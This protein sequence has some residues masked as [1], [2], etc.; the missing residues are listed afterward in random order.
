[1]S[2][3][4]DFLTRVS[5]PTE[6]RV[7]VIPQV[8]KQA[9]IEI[10]LGE[11]LTGYID[12]R[13][14]VKP[15]TRL[16]LKVAA[17]QLI[18]YFGAHRSL[19]SIT[20]GCADEW[21][22]WLATEVRDGAIVV[23]R[24][25]AENT[26]RRLCGRA[27]QFF[28]A[29]LRKRLISVNPFGNMKRI[30]V[31]TNEARVYFL[32]REDS[33]RVLDACPDG[34]WRVIFALARWG[35]LRCPSE[36]LSLEWSGID[37]DR[38]RMKIHSPKTEH[39]EGGAYRFCPLFPEVRRELSAIYQPGMTGYIVN[40]RRRRAAL[41]I[42]GWQNSNLRTMFR[43]I[44]WRSGVKPWPKVFQNLRSTRE[45]ELCNRFPVHVVCA[46]LGHSALIA[47]KH[48]LQT[49]DQHF[50]AA[51]LEDGGAGNGGAL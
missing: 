13:T 31:G 41:G 40:E 28:L 17:T 47:R 3:L 22:L 49:T 39:H 14:D 26:I 12:R 44:I 37:W 45:T 7:Q 20:E 30:L 33:Q 1:M 19:V 43:E 36:V 21:R 9:T 38:Q 51:T 42:N 11:F 16:N 8:E 46:W 5:A 24:K 4:N 23:R 48:Y 25:L 50:F 18:A 15:S 10:K 35:G 6:R 32:D 34:E 29:A 2:S 27:R